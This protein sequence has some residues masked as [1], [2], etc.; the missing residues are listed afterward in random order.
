[1][2]ILNGAGAAEAVKTMRLPF[3]IVLDVDG[4]IAG[5][6]AVHG[7]PTALVITSDGTEIA[8]VGGTANSL[9]LKLAAYVDLAAG[10]V[11]RAT[12]ERRATTHEVV[13]DRVVESRSSA[14]RELYEAER[15]IAAGRFVEAKQI[16]VRVLP[17][18]HDPARANYLMGR[19]L[20][21]E[22][23]WA[24]AARHYRAA[25][26]GSVIGKGAAGFPVP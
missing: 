20:E 14:S 8:R 5:E 7:W 16:L 26:D 13:G 24:G 23:D 25:R 17:Q 10:R 6:L 19:V 21:H 3:P 22:Q 11:D 15:L 4:A 1:V 12:A 2:V 18:G 9:A